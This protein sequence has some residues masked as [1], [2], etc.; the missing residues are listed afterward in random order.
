[1][2]DGELL[3]RM[4]ASLTGLLRVVGGGS[5]GARLIE[6]GG[7]VAS[8]CPTL[9]DRSLFSSVVYADGE[10]LRAAIGDLADDYD[11]AGVNAWTVWA[12]P[13]DGDT[14]GALEAA[15]H[16][17]DAE[18]MAM[19]LDLDELVEVEPDRLAVEGGD[20]AVAGAINEVAFGLP[21]GAMAPGIQQLDDAH[22]HLYLG[23]VDGRPLTCAMTYEVDGEAGVFMVATDPA[24][25]GRGLASQ[26]LTHALRESR[27]RGCT[28]S[29]LQATR[30]GRPVYQ[31]LGYRD[32]GRIGM[33]ERRR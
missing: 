24:A 18:P 11:R 8:V 7:V 27:E 5:P 31:R 3:E 26:L 33:W 12:H 10:E 15:G 29:T 16:R 2:G 13:D 4:W 22:A 9:P 6:R 28:S 25:Q 21:A 30:V 32:L 1:M 17:L 20:V 14:A 23:T 19:G